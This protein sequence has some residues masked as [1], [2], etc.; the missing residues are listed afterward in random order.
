MEQG[1]IVPATVQF[2]ARGLEEGGT[3]HYVGTRFGKKFSGK[4]IPFGALETRYLWQ[5][6]SGSWGSYRS[7]RCFP[8]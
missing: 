1:I 6:L 8:A 3:N 7:Y 4:L 2:R 5:M